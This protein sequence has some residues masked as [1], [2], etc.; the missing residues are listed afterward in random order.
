MKS[1]NSLTKIRIPFEDP[2]KFGG[3]I[4]E[5]LW[6]TVLG[7]DNYRIENDPLTEFLCFRDIVKAYEIDG[8]LTFNR[9]VMHSSEKR[10]P[11]NR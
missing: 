6:V 11:V 5:N 8:E 7:N 1:K 2:G 4:A 10:P 9:V 3:C